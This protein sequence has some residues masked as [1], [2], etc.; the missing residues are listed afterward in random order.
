LLA[1]AGYGDAHLLTAAGSGI[2][3]GDRAADGEQV[4]GFFC[5]EYTLRI[6]RIQQF[7]ARIFNLCHGLEAE[8]SYGVSANAYLTPAASQGLLAH[9][10]DHDVIVLQIDGAKEWHVFDRAAENPREARIVTPP[11][12]AEPRIRVVLQA[13][14]SLYVPRG[15]VHAAAAADDSSLHLSVGLYPATAADLLKHAV[16]EL[17]D[18]PQLAQPLPPG[19]A[20]DPDQVTLALAQ[21]ANYL[22]QHCDEQASGRRAAQSF[23]R[24]W[25]RMVI[26]PPT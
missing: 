17:A 15:F 4:H 26:Q 18:S 3:V 12:A 10:D 25:Q 6:S 16:S 8:L 24:P 9:Y 19:F 11:E 21:A 20:A 14:E 5:Q 1:A 22:R 23:C 7:A 2:D 13:G